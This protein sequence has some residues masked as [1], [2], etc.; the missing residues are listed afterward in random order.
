MFAAVSVF[1]RFVPPSAHACWH[2]CVD[3]CAHAG[4][5]TDPPVVDQVA[6]APTI[7]GVHFEVAPSEATGLPDASVDLVT[8]A[9]AMHW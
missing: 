2:S 4:Y 3:I 6:A 1:D 9:Q 7:A 8:V 5:A